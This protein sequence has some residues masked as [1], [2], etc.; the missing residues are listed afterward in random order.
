MPID[1]TAFQSI[2]WPSAAKELAS[3]DER[4][5]RC[6]SP[7][8]L[9]NSCRP[10]TPLS[11]A[12]T[13]NVLHTRVRIVNLGLPPPALARSLTESPTASYLGA[14]TCFFAIF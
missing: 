8:R 7:K 3:F 1:G 9:S 11:L 14:A 5:L 13:P 4:S 6:A 12:Q 10:S 2:K